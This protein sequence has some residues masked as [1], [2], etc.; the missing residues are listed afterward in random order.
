[1]KG[2]ELNWINEMSYQIKQNEW[3]ERDVPAVD[4]VEFRQIFAYKL[5]KKTGCQ[6]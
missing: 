3:F 5:L 4:K 1:M 6:G 2:N